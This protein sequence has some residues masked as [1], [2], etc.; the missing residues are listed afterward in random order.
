MY[1]GIE[2]AVC[3]DRNHNIK[4][5]FLFNSCVVVFLV[6]IADRWVKNFGYICYNAITNSVLQFV[7]MNNAGKT[8]YITNDFLQQKEIKVEGKKENLYVTN[9]KLSWLSASLMCCIICSLLY[10]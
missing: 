5:C 6:Y 3:M 9:S 1:G 7:P 8:F 10:T 2:S 4:T